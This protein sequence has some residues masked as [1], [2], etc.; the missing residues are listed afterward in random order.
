MDQIDILQFDEE[1]EVTLSAEERDIADRWEFIVLEAKLAIG[2]RGKDVRAKAEQQILSVS[3]DM[4]EFC[5]LT[6]NGLEGLAN[7][8]LNVLLVLNVR[9]APE[10]RFRSTACIAIKKGSNYLAHQAAVR[11]RERWQT[12]TNPFWRDELDRYRADC[13]LQQADVNA[14]ME[15]KKRIEPNVARQSAPAHVR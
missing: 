4:F 3:D 14:Y 6:F 8:L 5:G 7:G 2:R 1:Q 11:A 10:V 12:R 15:T 13:K 9:A